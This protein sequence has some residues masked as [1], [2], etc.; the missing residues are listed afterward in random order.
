MSH[1]ACAVI[2]D[3][4]K[5]LEEL[6][7]PYQENNMENVPEQYLEFR[8]ETDEYR[9]E[10]EEKT[11]LF[12]YDPKDEEG[13]ILY[14]HWHDVRKTYE[15]DS[16]G[17]EAKRYVTPEGW[18]DVILPYKTVFPTLDDF[19]RNIYN[20]EPDENGRYGTW[21]NPQAKWDWWSEYS[22]T[23][24]VSRYVGG[25]NIRVSDIKFNPD[26]E[27][28][29]AREFI[30]AHPDGDKGIHDLERYW[31][32]RD[33]TDEQYIEAERYVNFWACIT[34][35]GKWHEAAEMYAFGISE[36]VGGDVHYRWNLEFEDRFLR[37]YQDCTLVVVDCH[38]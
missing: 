2:M 37:P 25:N 5:T 28:A 4:T 17:I 29:R 10:Y 33:M 38:I 7:A 32:M 34:P 24:W 15:K 35:D 26:R 3:G 30:R 18:V 27:E 1:F 8:D 12:C 23:S 20:E 11:I 31:A 16:L 19:M 9:K 6:M 22:P 21:E 14:P 36:D 13:P